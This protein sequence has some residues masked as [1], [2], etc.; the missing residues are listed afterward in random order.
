MSQAT[1][2]GQLVDSGGEPCI[3]YFEWGTST[4]YGFETPPQGGVISGMSFNATVY[5]LAEGVLYHFRA[6]AK[7]NMAIAYGNDM[8]FAIPVG[9]TIP[10]L[11][12]D[13]GLAQF[14]EVLK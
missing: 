2:N 1:L 8:V 12:D 14:L 11:L 7:N 4:D 6:V 5:G 9:S 13:A 10:V 3:V